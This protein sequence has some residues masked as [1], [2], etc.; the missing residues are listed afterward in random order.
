M[1]IYLLIILV[2]L[3]ACEA[4]I[5]EDTPEPIDSEQIPSEPIV[6]PEPIAT[7]PI[8]TPTKEI[9]D[10][11]DNAEQTESCETDEDCV[12]A[13]CCHASECTYKNNAPDCKLT[14]CTQECVPNTLDCQQGSCQ[15]INSQCQAIIKQ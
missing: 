3:A 10:D 11:L 15:C 7:D 1:K 9:Q 4:E 6:N 5:F 2:L 14:F 12:K 13:T 8:K